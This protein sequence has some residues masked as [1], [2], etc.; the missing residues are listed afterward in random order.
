MF[1]GFRDRR[2]VA[3][4]DKPL[5]HLFVFSSELSFFDS[6]LNTEQAIQFVCILIWDVANVLCDTVISILLT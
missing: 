4:G 5:V 1:L 3:W 6:G 2:I